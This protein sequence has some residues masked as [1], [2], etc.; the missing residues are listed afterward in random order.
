ML[1]SNRP[2]DMKTHAQAVSADSLTFEHAYLVARGVRPLAL[3]GHCPTDALCLHRAQQQLESF[4]AAGA[5]AFVCDRGDGFA[6]YGF[7]GAQWAIDLYRWSVQKN[8]AVPV[9]QQHRIIGLLLGYSTAAISD[10]ETAADP[11]RTSGSAA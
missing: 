2:A 5:I 3:V 8:D 4:A 11:A 1:A 10:F 6:D 7:A 9:A